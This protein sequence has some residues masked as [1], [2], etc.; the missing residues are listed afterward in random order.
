MAQQ[1][2]GQGSRGGSGASEEE[3][4]VWTGL[5]T[6][7]V[8]SPKPGPSNCCG[9][10]WGPWISVTSPPS[11]R[12]PMTLGEPGEDLYSLS[13]DKGAPQGHTPKLQSPECLRPPQLTSW[14]QTGM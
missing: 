12:L 10:G 11:P 5:G 14:L 9:C 3:G 7:L 1:G 6:A 13:T 4:P 2:D 8:L